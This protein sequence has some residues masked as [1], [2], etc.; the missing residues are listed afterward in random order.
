M[1]FR[2]HRGEDSKIRWKRRVSGAPSAAGSPR[3]D[4]ARKKQVA[5]AFRLQAG[6]FFWKRTEVRKRVKDGS[7]GELSRRFDIAR[8]DRFGN[9]EGVEDEAER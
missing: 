3:R 7:I 2:S 1:L 4:R 5:T 9:R 6:D 8:V